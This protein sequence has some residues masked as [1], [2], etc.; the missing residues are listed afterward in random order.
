MEMRGSNVYRWT[1]LL[2]VICCTVLV[3]LVQL[4]ALAQV[5]F[6][7]V[8]NGKMHI[9]L[10][11]THPEKELDSFIKQF[12]LGHLGLKYFIKTGNADSIHA[13]GWELSMNNE[14]G[15][16]LTKELLSS[17]TIN[18]PVGRITFAAKSPPFNLM[19]P[20][21]SNT[22]VMGYNQFRNKQPFAIRDS[23]VTFFLR[24]NNTARKVYL[25]G[26]FNDWNPEAL[27]MMKTDSGWIADVI[28]RPGKYWYKFV[29][30]GNWKMDADNRISENDGMGNTNSVFYFTNT[31]FTLD[32][33]TNAKRVYLAGSF[34]RW[35]ERDIPMIKTPTGWKVQLYLADGTH[36][37][38]FIVDNN[39]ITDP[40][41][42]NKLPNE[43]NDFNSFLTIGKPHIFKLEGHQSAKSV[44]LSGSFNGWREDELYMRKTNEGWELPYVLGAGNHEY[45]FIV[46]GRSMPDPMNKM[47]T[48]SKTT[49][50]L[51]L[52]PNYT[53]R[54][55]GHQQAK[56][57]FLSGNFN[58]W[59]PNSLAMKKEDGEWVFTVHLSPGKHL[60]K[61][62]VD[63][64][65][66]T[67][68]ANELWEENEHNTR[69]SVL[70]MEENKQHSK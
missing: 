11:K 26:S 28:L 18:D 43:F 1:R 9:V 47:E 29:V 8:K 52:Q 58:N 19:F 16:M 48:G 30:D 59:S 32:G 3:L 34:N 54:L 46:D 57:V 45:K 55:K 60:Y 5:P 12:D 39:W 67:D 6:Y 42:Q 41:N 50:Y 62:V 68:P 22:M 69:N 31:L 17:G 70:W 51:V 65:W 33:Y 56:T 49:S 37:Y 25:A 10:L 36:T 2:R 23:I 61:F 7:T 27:A 35:A 13:N 21:V 66:I 20:S 53:F 40:G 4:P 14:T 44:I 38:R 24:N 63:G 15:F 64:K